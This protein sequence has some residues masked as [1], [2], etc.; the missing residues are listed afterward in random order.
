MMLKA[1]KEFL[2]F[3]WM[4]PPSAPKDHLTVRIY[5]TGGQIMVLYGVK[6][7]STSKTAEGGFASYKIEW[8][9]GFK[10]P[11]FSVTLDHISAIEVLKG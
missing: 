8:H 7:I 11:M 6:E 3:I 10:L 4:G 5:L 2:S 9:D 1:L